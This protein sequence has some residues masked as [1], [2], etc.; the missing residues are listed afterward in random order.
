MKRPALCTR[1]PESALLVPPLGFLLL[2]AALNITVHAGA[3]LRLATALLFLRALR[4]ALL[5]LL[6]LT[7]AIL[8]ILMCHDEI[9]SSFAWRGESLHLP[10]A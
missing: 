8:L 9:L 2:A 6:A 7:V 1:A 10:P 3:L 4:S 5:V